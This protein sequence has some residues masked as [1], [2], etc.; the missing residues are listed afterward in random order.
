MVGAGPAGLVAAARAAELGARTTLLTRGD[1]GG[2]AAT[3]GPVPV[4]ALAHAA[5]LMRDARQLPE[6]GIRVGEPSLD[7][8]CLLER[9][10]EVVDRVQEHA[11]LRSKLEST[12]VTIHEQ[13]GT[14]HFADP[15]TIECTAGLR[16]H[17]DAVIVC[18]GGKSR[19]L[20][21]PGF[22]LTATHSD[23]WALTSVPP[24]MVVVGAGA[25]GAQVASVFNAFGCQ[26]QLLERGPRILPT[27]D[28]DVSRV[29]AD[30]FRATGIA[31]REGFDTLDRVEKSG[32]TYRLVFSANGH[33]EVAE[34]ALIVVAIGWQA[35]VHGLRVDEMGVATTPRGYI[36][37]D[38]Y[39]RTSVEHV[40]AAG[41]VTGRLML[42]PQALHDGYVAATNAVRGPT[43][44]M[45]SEIN[46][47]GSFTDPEYAQVGLTE[48]Q[49]REK[50]D[51]LTVTA[52][53]SGM[54]RPIIDGRTV[55]FAKLIVDRQTHTIVG[56]HIVGERAVEIA[57][58]AA[59]AMAGG[60]RVEDLARIPI[61]FPTYTNLFSRAT[62][63]AARRLDVAGFWDA[64][65]FE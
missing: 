47:I 52:H 62:L 30:A 55:G 42:V 27:E 51:V 43:L 32:E 1:F 5:R 64:A 20:P 36:A 22:E 21:I 18:T 63:M 28:E 23:A 13:V 60:T 39:L 59:V 49:A 8:H 45:T 14:A 57:Q 31:V 65:E 38:E 33:V 2:M 58:V 56:C 6:Y 40:F 3:D 34:A 35:D 54:V 41:D 10:G 9:V 50:L 29:V 19:Q 53:Y 16:V 46:P 48:V 25:T 7:L 26:V 4:R 61:S 15:H 37:V 17:G 11:L 12:G 24:S 44:Q